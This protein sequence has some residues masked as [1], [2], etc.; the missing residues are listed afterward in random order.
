MININI[1]ESGSKLS[2]QDELVKYILDVLSENNECT[3]PYYRFGCAT[4]VWYSGKQ[5]W[6]EL[7]SDKHQASLGV[8]KEVADAFTAKGYLVEDKHFCGNN[9]ELFI[10]R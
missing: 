1:P 2:A 4:G 10:K 6:R 8:I 5:P 3:I 9:A 7:E